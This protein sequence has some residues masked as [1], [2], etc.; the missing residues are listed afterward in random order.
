MLIFPKARLVLLAVPKTASSALENVLAPHAEIALTAPPRMKHMPLRR[1]E[2]HFRHLLEEER[3]GRYETVAV[4]RN[5]ES[6]LASWWRYRSRPEIAG[7]PQY[8]GE[9]DFDDF[10]RDYLREPQPEHARVGSQARFLD[11][12]QGKAG[13][14]HLFRYE[15]LERL[16]DFLAERLGMEI[17]LPSVNASPPRTGRLSPETAACLHAA[18]QPDF[19]LWEKALH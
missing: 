11:A 14:D 18:L 5:P 17:S 10:V 13:V 9:L 12:R 3:F 19:E 8:A 6:W 2:R 16:V 15:T 7:R 1:F 4:I